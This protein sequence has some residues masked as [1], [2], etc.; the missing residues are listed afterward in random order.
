MREK[1][2][3]IDSNCSGFMFFERHKSTI[4]MEMIKPQEAVAAESRLGYFL[5]VIG[6]SE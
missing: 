4:V 3:I 2:E 5:H 6:S 1:I